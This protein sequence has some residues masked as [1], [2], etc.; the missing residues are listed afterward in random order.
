MSGIPEVDETLVDA[1]EEFFADTVPSARTALDESPGLPTTLWSQTEE[2]GLTRI[3]IPEELGGSGGSLHD[4]LT[5]LLSAARHAAPVPLAET[6]LGS[7]LLTRAAV[8]VPP[9]VLTVVPPGPD[10]TRL[11]DVPWADAA[12]L[13][14]ALA[15]GG[16]DAARIIAVDPRR[17]ITGSGEN[18]AGEPTADVDVGTPDVDV[19][20][21]FARDEYVWLGALCRTAQIA[22]ALQAVAQLTQRYTQERVQFGKPIARFQAVQQHIVTVTQAA[23]IT[24]TALWVAAR[25]WARDPAASTLEVSAAKL[26]ADESARVA[27][28]TA[29]QAHGAM[30]MTREY[31]LHRFTR[32]LNLWRQQFGTERELA[33]RLGRAASGAPSFAR[34]LTDADHDVAVSCPAT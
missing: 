25:A 1:V 33:S 13:V 31:P 22:G 20:A 19:D 27:A 17:R 21:P 26:I 29:H 24:T 6:Y 12:T 8:E 9:G 28:R 34:L 15:D 4:L 3:G 10:A 5:V 2:L 18:L 30:G 14:V 16:S 23:E 32:R 7:W 11:H